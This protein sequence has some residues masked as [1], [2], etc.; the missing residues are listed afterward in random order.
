MAY[1]MNKDT[2]ILLGLLAVVLL[3]SAK[4]FKDY[5]YRNRY[6]EGMTLVSQ[7]SSDQLRRP[8][9]GSFNADIM[10]T[11]TLGVELPTTGSLSVAWT[12]AMAG[13]VVF[14]TA[15]SNYTATA[16]GYTIPP[17]PS[18]ASASQATF[19][20]ST[21]KIPSGTQIK[22]TIKGVTIYSKSTTD[23][24]KINITISA[25]NDT[26]S[27]IVVNILPFVSTGQAAGASTYTASTSASVS[28]IQNAISGINTR[29]AVTGENAPQA[30][31]V[32]SLTNARSALIALLA[33][34]YGT[35]KEAGQVFESGALYEAQK[36]A[37]DFITKEKARATSNATALSSDNL[38]KRRMA[39]INT[40]YTR[41][42]EANTDVMKNVIYVSIAL[43]ILAV[44]RKKEL[45]PGSISTLGVIFI[46]TMG[47]IIIGKQIFDI[48]RRNDHDFDKY[49][50][51][52]NESQMNQQKLIQ[53]APG[54]TSLSDIYGP[55]YGASCCDVGTAWNNDMKKC[56]PSANVVS[57][58]AMWTAPPPGST[59]G[60]LTIKLKV[61]T[62]LVASD[63]ITVSLPAGLFKGAPVLTSHTQLTGTILSTTSNTLTVSSSGIGA[64]AAVNDIIITG[65]S[66]NDSSSSLTKQLKVSTSK[67]TTEIAI[68]IFNM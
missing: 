14:P 60:S 54:T 9:T 48:M 3:C 28:D 5:L 30:R 34:T 24:T 16:S 6:I 12:G 57:G 39:Q 13:D 66:V 53:P 40:Y 55:C 29:L 49:D 23:T 31:E 36:T 51:E 27:G 32:T 17:P 20:S 41:N 50:W 7:E 8:S 52:F 1:Q 26:N 4:L 2:K 11:V 15:K 45:I 56:I 35:I 67:D 63:T 62:A 64:N 38:N 59:A 25:G 21:V 43:I 18:D 37:I 22:I 10:F 44:L 65:M 61:L 42:Y 33:S 47:G 46:L 58:T 68:N 19:G